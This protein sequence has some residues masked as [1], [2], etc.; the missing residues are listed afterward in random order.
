MNYILFMGLGCMFGIIGIATNFV[1]IF[2]GEGYD[3]VVPLLY[4]FSPIIVIIGVSNCLGSHYYTPI[5]KRAE[6]SKYLIAGS[7]VNL[8]LN[9]CLIPKLGANGAAIASIT[10]ELLITVLYFMHCEDYMTLCMLWTLGWK[11]SL[12]AIVMC[13]VVVMV[14]NILPNTVATL[15]IQIIVGSI[16]YVMVLIIIKDEWFAGFVGA[17]FR[18]ILNRLKK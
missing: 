3:A 8:I 15:A 4:I 7:I 5:G 1:P 17:E 2:F 11:K 14:G 9:L 16:C 18:K 10:A 12:A 6:S 13:V